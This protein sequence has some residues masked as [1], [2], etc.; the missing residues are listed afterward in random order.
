MRMPSL[1]QGLAAGAARGAGRLSQKLGRGGGTTIPGLLLNRL[2]PEATAEMAL[3]VPG[4]VILVSGTNGKTTTARL[5]RA[6]LD[7]SGIRVVA[8]T[9]GSNLERGVATALLNSE[10]AEL[11]LFEVDEAALP[12]L[13]AQTRP[14]VVTL[15]NLFRDQ[16]DRYG[17]LEHLVDRWRQAV[18]E[19]DPTTTVI[20][21]AD[22][23]AVAE[24][25]SGHPS[26]VSYGIEDPRVGRDRLPHAADT[27]NCRR[28]AAPLHYDMGTIAHLGRW[29]C[30]ECESARAF[31][32]VRATRVEL[33]GLDG[34]RLS[35][36]T[37]QGPMEVSL[38]LPGMHNSY[39]ALAATATASALALDPQ[40][41]GPALAK[42]EAAFGRA[43]RTQMGSTRVT[44]LL[45][46]NPAGA[47]ENIRTMLLEGGPLHLLVLLNDRTADGQDV[48]WIW[49]VDYELLLEN[50][51]LA[52]LTVSG[53]RAYDMALRFRY[54]GFDPD[55]LSVVPSVPAA[56]NAALQSSSSTGDLYVLPT[57]T[58]L[59]EFQAVLA[60]RGLVPSFW[61]DR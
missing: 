26:T 38:R 27:I 40:S 46:K 57:Y 12:G 22:D 7:A 28:C 31:P 36:A 29:S 55:R 8:N 4:G 25:A 32:D 17:E 21:N 5:V 23:P 30:P 34:Q 39:N 9:A 58:A 10:G 11:A 59:L 14:R 53:D 56:L 43:E 61:E 42:R 51:R 2:R 16:L 19:L 24:I 41:I 48:S 33:H 6:A 18:A 37:P 54:A 15:M 35:I 3:A 60:D 52:S 45:A 1:P 20:Y 44:T 13:M 47:N 50:D 49:D